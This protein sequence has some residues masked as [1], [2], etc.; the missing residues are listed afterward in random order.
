MTSNFLSSILF[1]IFYFLFFCV[2]VGL[3]TVEWLYIRADIL[4]LKNSH[5]GQLTNEK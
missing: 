4:C 5:Y 2:C 1:F 3:V